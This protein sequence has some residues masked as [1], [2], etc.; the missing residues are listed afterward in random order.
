MNRAWCL[1]FTLSSWMVTVPAFADE[2]AAP[3]IESVESE[4]V[5]PDAEPAP[6]PGAFHRHG[7]VEIDGGYAVQSLYGIPITGMGFSGIL[8]VVQREFSVGFIF[9]FLRGWTEAG[10]QTTNVEIGGI[11][12][13]RIDRLVLGGGL[14]VGTFDVSRVTS[15]SPLLS[16]SAGA[17]VR[18]S[19]DLETFGKD[20]QDAFYVLGKNCGTCGTTCTSG[21][22]CVG[23]AC[24]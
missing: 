13:H 16:T 1:G 19:Y 4:E 7:L 24:H 11:F 21:Q 10:L 3:R 12:E 17:L 20:D 6:P 9:E 15:S 23:G 22:G 18:L 5:T 2:P 14:R 8:G